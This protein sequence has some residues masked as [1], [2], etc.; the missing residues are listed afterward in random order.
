MTDETEQG[1]A[2]RRLTASVA[3]LR[4]ELLVTQAALAGLM[5]E[6]ARSGQEPAAQLGDSIVRLLGFADSAAKGLA[7]QPGMASTA[8]TAAA[9]R[10]AEWA[11]GILS[12]KA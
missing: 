12:A 8:P 4:A 5:A 1:Q 10:I 6:V 3:E 7:L 2:I 11:E 9:L